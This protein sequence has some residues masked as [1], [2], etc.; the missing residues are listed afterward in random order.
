ML[1][2]FFRDVGVP[3]GTHANA[4]PVEFYHTRFEY[5]LVEQ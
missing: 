1:D 4:F 3:D 2:N 5:A